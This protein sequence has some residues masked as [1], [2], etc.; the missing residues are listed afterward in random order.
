VLICFALVYGRA[1]RFY[2]RLSYMRVSAA[3]E[4]RRLWGKTPTQVVGHLFI[5]ARASCLFPSSARRR[6]ANLNNDTESK[7]VR[8]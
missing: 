3:V 6:R 4:C 5:G 2:A 8:E 7:R 1:K